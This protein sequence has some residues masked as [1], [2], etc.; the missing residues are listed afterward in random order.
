MGVKDV[1]A[2]IRKAGY[3]SKNKT[4]DNSVGV[5]LADMPNVLKVGRG[6]YRLR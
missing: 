3:K 5:A 1:T 4:L 6:Q 2:A